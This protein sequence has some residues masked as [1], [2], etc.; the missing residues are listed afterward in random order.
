MIVLIEMLDF[1]QGHK[2]CIFER[3]AGRNN[4]GAV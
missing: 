4:S 2:Y 1:L 3:V